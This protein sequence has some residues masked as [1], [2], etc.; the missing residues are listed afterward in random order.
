[1]EKSPDAFR[2]ISEVAEV[3]DTPAHVLRFWESRFPQIRPI[4]RAGGRRYY[5][6]TDVA[7]LAGI[8]QLLHDEG[9]TIRG[10]QKVLREQGVRHVQGLGEGRLDGF[11]A[12]TEAAEIEAALDAEFLADVEPERKFAPPET[13]FEP[14]A[15]IVPL[16]RPKGAPK[17]TVARLLADTP[18]PAN[19]PGPAEPVP[20]APFVEVEA[21]ENSAT[22]AHI[23]TQ[24]ESAPTKTTAAASSGEPLP[25][26]EPE[27][28]ET[29]ASA[30]RP[31][32]AFADLTPP[33]ATEAPNPA[34]PDTPDLFDDLPLLARMA[35]EVSD[36]DLAALAALDGIPPD[37]ETEAL[38]AAI[39]GGEDEGTDL[40]VELPDA[41]NLHETAESLGEAASEPVGAPA[42]AASPP[43]QAP[44]AALPPPL[45]SRL[46]AL[47]RPP[48]AETRA[49]LQALLDRARALQGSRASAKGPG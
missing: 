46:R 1:M 22:F 43:A 25:E 38:I 9:L 18:G 32:P 45:A 21:G 27:P 2:T 7:L 23:H 37:A 15:G 41:E 40:A 30:P 24:D 31:P 48:A 19:Q 42:R 4:K 11:G 34:G 17:G 39:A 29:A 49:T 14:Q 33:A 6:P 16:T 13:E 26:G 44:A 35:D 36:E 28:E 5:R 3:L 8:R 47:P 10:V 12:L 20:E